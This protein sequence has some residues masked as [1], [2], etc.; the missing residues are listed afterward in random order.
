M[1]EELTA[2][3]REFHRIPEIGFEE[4]ETSALIAEKLRALGLEPRTGV[5]GTGVVALIEGAHPGRTLLLRADMDGLPIEERTGLPY[6]SVHPNRM[7]ACGHDT[8]V[9]MLLAAAR[10]LLE[11]RDEIH[12]CVKLVFQPAEEG[13]GGAAAMI[14]DGVLEDPHVDAAIGC[15]IWNSMPVGLVG[16]REGP[17]MAASDRVNI[18]I[19]GQGGHGAMP[20]VCADAI[21]AAAQVITTLQT[22][23]SRRVAPLEAGVVTIGTI[24]GGHAS[25]IIADRVEMEGTVRSFDEDLW[26]QMPGH[27]EQVVTGVCAAMGVRGTVEY[28]RG[29]PTTTNDPAMTALVRE[30]AMEALGAERVVLPEQS[31]GGED[32]SLFLRAAPG[33]FFFVGSQNPA[34]GADKPHHH[35]E[36]EVDEDALPNGVKVLV[37]SALRYLASSR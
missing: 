18:V 23:V 13:L 7:H 34:K 14:E 25:N 33:C 22:I 35:P 30:A 19:E 10:I 17:I 21:V 36:F 9:T 20:H 37:A 27:I 32:M 12:G 29:V 28:R 16:V 26:R 15:H 6:S 2:T 31:T 24:H 8:H 3:R 11:R 5:G 1:A 4:Y